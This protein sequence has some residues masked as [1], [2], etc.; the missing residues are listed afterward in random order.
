M[1]IIVNTRFLQTSKTQIIHKI[2]HKS[3]QEGYTN[4]CRTFSDSCCMAAFDCCSCKRRNSFSADRA[5]ITLSFSVAV[6]VVAFAVSWFNNTDCGAGVIRGRDE[7]VP[8]VERTGRLFVESGKE[9]LFVFWGPFRKEL[10]FWC[11]WCDFLDSSESSCAMVPFWN[12]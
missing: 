6:V 5:A 7:V 3:T 10:L 4:T 11:C 9:Q 12:I 1:C 2:T 8:G